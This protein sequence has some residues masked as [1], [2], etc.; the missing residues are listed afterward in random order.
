MHYHTYIDTLTYT[1]QGRAFAHGEKIQP[2]SPE[3]R[4]HMAHFL[5]KVPDLVLKG[6]VKSNPV[7]LFEGGLFG[8]N[9]GMQY[10]MEG[11]NSGEKIVFRLK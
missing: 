6:Q 9:D 5:K 7:K 8:I 3:D 11:K 10:M 1:S 4:A 2:A